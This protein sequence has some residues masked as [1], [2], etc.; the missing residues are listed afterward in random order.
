MNDAHR[1]YHSIRQRLPRDAEARS[2]LQALTDAIRQ[3]N[4]ARRH[5]AVDLLLAAK[6]GA[7]RFHHDR[8]TRGR[9]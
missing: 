7:L 9:R 5:Y 1:S 2:V 3:A 6:D 4:A 8:D